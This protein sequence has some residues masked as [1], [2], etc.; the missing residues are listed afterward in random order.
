MTKDITVGYQKVDEDYLRERAIRLQDLIDVL[1][2]SITSMDHYLVLKSLNHSEYFNYYLESGEFENTVNVLEK[3]TDELQKIGNELVPDTE[4]DKKI[5][6]KRFAT[7][8][9]DHK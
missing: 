8:T 6:A 9:G 1:N 3:I 4:T 2:M 5:Y 7:K